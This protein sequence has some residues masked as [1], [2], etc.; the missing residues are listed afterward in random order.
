M[1]EPLE[2]DDEEELGRPRPGERMVDPPE[3]CPVCVA[4]IYIVPCR[5][6]A[7]RARMEL[8]SNPGLAD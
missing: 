1:T 7:A 8:D 3:R 2:E 4:L 5:L 6:C